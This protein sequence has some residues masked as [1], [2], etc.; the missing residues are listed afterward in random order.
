MISRYPKQA[1]PGQVLNGEKAK[2]VNVQ[3][4]H[5]ANCPICGGGRMSKIHKDQNGRCARIM[6]ARIV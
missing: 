4:I 5:E 6:K 3:Y 1:T 2:A